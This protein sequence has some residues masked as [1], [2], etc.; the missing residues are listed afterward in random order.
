VSTLTVMTGRYLLDT[1]IVIGLF[2]GEAAIQSKVAL[3]SEIFVSAI[4]LGE[5]QFGA[6]KSARVNE[7]L[8]RINTFALATKV[9][10]C[11]ANT[12]SLYGQIKQLLSLQGRPIPENDLWIAATA[13]QHELTLVSRDRHFAEI[14]SLV[15]VIW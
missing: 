10:A 15:T 1:N 5:L 9:L 7:N 8:E 4:V 13:R 3:A 11:N 6:R 14:E 2:A 12:A